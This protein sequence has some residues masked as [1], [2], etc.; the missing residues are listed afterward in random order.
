MLDICKLI[1]IFNEKNRFLTLSEI[2][3]EYINRYSAEGYKY[4]DAAIRVLINR[5]CCD[6]DL[7]LN[8]RRTF[9]SL[10]KKGSSGQL[11]GLYEWKFPDKNEIELDKNI[12][13]KQR[14]VNVY[15]RSEDVKESALKRANYLCEVCKEH[16][17]F[18]RKKDNMNY[19]EAHHLIPL[20]Y[21]KDPMFEF[22]NLDCVE[23]VVSL[24]SNCH[25][26]LHYGLDNKEL[27]DK[28]YNERIRMLNDKQIFVT[29]DQLYEF[30]N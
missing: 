14:V 11:Y 24:C 20:E 23:N 13:F 30:Y 3:E 6:R 5:N 27:L 7:N 22:T 2:Y 4:I 25:N 16:Q 18:K 1:S 21:Q 12:N 17:T 19:M 9:I 15:S 26:H 29:L 8:N 10:N 28:L